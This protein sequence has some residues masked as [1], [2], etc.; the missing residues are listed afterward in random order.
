MTFFMPPLNTARWLCQSLKRLVAG[1]ESSLSNY[2][3]DYLLEEIWL[4]INILVA[5]RGHGKNATR[6]Q[7]C[8]VEAKPRHDWRLGKAD[9]KKFRL[10]SPESLPFS[11]ECSGRN[12]N[13]VWA[14]RITNVLSAIQ[15]K[16]FEWD[17]QSSW[18]GWNRGIWQQWWRWR[19]CSAIQKETWHGQT[20]SKLLS[21]WFCDRIWC[22]LTVL[23]DEDTL[24][25]E[26]IGRSRTWN[27]KFRTADAPDPRCCQQAHQKY[28]ETLWATPS[29][30]CTILSPKKRLQFALLMHLWHIKVKA[31][32]AAK[33]Q[34][35]GGGK[36][37]SASL[38]I[39][40][41]ADDDQLV[42]PTASRGGRKLPGSLFGGTAGRSQA[43][44]SQGLFT[45]SRR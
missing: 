40:S 33:R 24:K 22:W 45:S 32:P 19:Q 30:D 21:A 37:S 3:C 10:S 7:S 13:I 17:W 20:T 2:P 42:Q 34:A 23:V 1:F 35:R 6:P 27:F 16:R 5:Y 39:D 18:L 36:I 28:K 9:L 26:M 4:Y 25:R 8:I 44:K 12:L 15:G 11:E 43:G 14:L 38:T 41:D 29:L 31:A